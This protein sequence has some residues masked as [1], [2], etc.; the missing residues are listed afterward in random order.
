[1]KATPAEGQRILFWGSA[2]ERDK[3]DGIELLVDLIVILGTGRRPDPQPQQCVRTT[4][5]RE[6]RV[7]AA[8]VLAAG[9]VIERYFGH[10]NCRICG[11]EL[12]SAD[13]GGHGFVWPE[14]AEH[15]VLEHDVW[16][17]GLDRLLERARS[18]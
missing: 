7:A 16:V 1:M 12:G 14:K 17:P 18:T 10:A 6:R 9:A 11:V 2:W 3:R 8:D 13:L 5:P 15:Y 4:I